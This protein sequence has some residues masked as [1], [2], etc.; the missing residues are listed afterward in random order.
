ML[1]T[2]VEGYPLVGLKIH[3]DILIE[4]CWHASTIDQSEIDDE[5]VIGLDYA[6]IVVILTNMMKVSPRL[7]FFIIDRVCKKKK[8]KYFD[9]IVGGLELVG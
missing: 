5:L 4:R 2:D 8:E 1:L 9:V 6:I 7:E 3:L